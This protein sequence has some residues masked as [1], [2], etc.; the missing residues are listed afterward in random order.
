MINMIRFLYIE[1]SQPLVGS[2]LA[3]VRNLYYVLRLEAKDRMTTIEHIG[4]DRTAFPDEDGYYHCFARA[5]D[6]RDSKIQVT[7]TA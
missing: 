1:A 6:S 4:I 2:K 7:L 5:V 3:T